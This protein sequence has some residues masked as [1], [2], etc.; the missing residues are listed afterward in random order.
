MPA[1]RFVLSRWQL[2]S[3]ALE[4]IAANPILGVGP[5]N[6]RLLYGRYAGLEIWDRSYHTNNLYLEFFVCTGLLGGSLFLWLLWRLLWVLRRQWKLASH[7]TLPQALGV[8]AAILAILVHGFF[9]Y[10]LEFTPNYLM[11]WS[12]LG[13]A[14]AALRLEEE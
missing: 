10:F 2:W 4:M 9:D 12:S 14:V 13:L 3:T 8:L 11:I 6:F 5:D 7:Q 1:P